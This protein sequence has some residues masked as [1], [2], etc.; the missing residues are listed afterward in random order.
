M[1]VLG[2]RSIKNTPVYID[3]ETAYY[4]NKNGEYYSEVAKTEKDICSLIEAGFEYVCD[5]EDG[6]IFRKPK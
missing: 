2:R 1:K 4:P 3:L 6:E 5:F